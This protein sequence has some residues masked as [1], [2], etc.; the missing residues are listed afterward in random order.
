M[1][2]FLQYS[3]LILIVVAAVVSVFEFVLHTNVMYLLYGHLIVPLNMN[4]VQVYQFFL[5]VVVVVV[6]VVVMVVL[7]SFV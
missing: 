1:V 3:L 6:V 4:Y 2:L 7:S 5:V